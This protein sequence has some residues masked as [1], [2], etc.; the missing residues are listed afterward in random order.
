MRACVGELRNFIAGTP[1]YVLG[2]DVFGQAGWERVR[3][4]F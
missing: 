2:D 1:L 4:Q 3:G